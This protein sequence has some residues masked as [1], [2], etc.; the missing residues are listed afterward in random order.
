M[1]WELVTAI[2]TALALV[3]TIAIWILQTRIQNRHM[4][5]QISSDMVARLNEYSQVEIEHPELVALLDRPYEREC[6]GARAAV[7]L[8]DMRLALVEEAYLQHEKHHTVQTDE[9]MTWQRMLQR[10]THRAI[11]PGYWKLAREG[12]HPEFAEMVDEELQ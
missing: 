1:N 8:M 5:A 3:A 9:W 2:A 4:R 7:T 6:D 12:F 10:W 11:F